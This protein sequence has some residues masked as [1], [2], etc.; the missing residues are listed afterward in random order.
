MWPQSDKQI[1]GYLQDLAFK[2]VVSTQELRIR[3]QSLRSGKGTCISTGG[4]NMLESL[5]MKI[6]IVSSMKI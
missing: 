2:G 1:K 4:F 6:L 3:E 5:S